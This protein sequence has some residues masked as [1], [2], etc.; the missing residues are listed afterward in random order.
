M[1]NHDAEELIARGRALLATG[2]A[3]D[4]V[5]VFADAY[6]LAVAGGE[7]AAAAL[8]MLGRAQAE[9]AVHELSC[10]ARN[11]NAALDLLNTLAMPQARRAADLLAQIDHYRYLHDREGTWVSSSDGTT[12]DGFGA[13]S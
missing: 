3:L 8:A 12:A 1:P 13:V 10:A 11:A 2:Q 7:Q 4:A 5:Q 6:A 9:F